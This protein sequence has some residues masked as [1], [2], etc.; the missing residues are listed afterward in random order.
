ME[1]QRLYH[2][3]R[4]FENRVPR[5]ISGLKRDEIIGDWRKLHNEEL[6]NLYSSSIII[7]KIKST[8]MRLAGYVAHRTMWYAYRVL[9]QTIG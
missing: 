6:R 4:T 8:R 5:R 1:A 3:L 9:V 2:V 7:T